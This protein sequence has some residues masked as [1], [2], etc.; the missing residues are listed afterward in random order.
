MFVLAEFDRLYFPLLCLPRLLQQQQ[1]AKV[2][3]NL[4]GE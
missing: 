2:A 3:L 4:R 1:Q